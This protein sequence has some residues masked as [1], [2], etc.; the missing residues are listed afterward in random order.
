MKNLRMSKISTKNILKKIFNRK[1]EKKVKKK[2]TKKEIVEEEIENEPP[3][4]GLTFA[5]PSAYGASGKNAFIGVSYGASTQDGLFTFYD[6]SDDKVADGSMNFGAGIGDPNQ[7]AAEVSVGIISLTCQEG[8]SCW[9]ADGTAGL[10]IHK[11]VDSSLINGW[12]LGYS[13]LIRWGEASDFA[14]I[15]GVASRDFKINNKAVSYTHLTLP[16]KRIV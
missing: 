5:V 11:K 6:S 16:T 15:Y 2:V 13:D 4:P 1:A 14:T 10:K 7:L 12:G 3:T 8:K 9:G